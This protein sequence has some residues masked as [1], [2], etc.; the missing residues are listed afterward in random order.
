MRQANPK[1][2]ALARA[3]IEPLGYELV[4]V[5]HVAGGR[6]A[7][8]RVFIDREE[9]ITVDD[10]ALV[11]HQLSGQF[12]LDDPIPG[13]Y[14]LEVSSPGLDRPLF[15]AEQMRRFEGQRA[16]VRLAEKQN[17]RR[18]FEGMLAG[19]VAG[20]GTSGGAN[21]S[22]PPPVD[23]VGES[24]AG[25]AGHMTGQQLCLRL[26]DGEIASLPLALIESARLVPLL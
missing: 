14:E 25:M 11:S 24:Q 3:V 15:T 16:R 9:G 12:D 23:L 22:E 21:G 4:G 6:H 10:C 1:L 8:V 5:E 18:N 2:T 26:D 17:G 20:V 7:V 13:Q 19:V